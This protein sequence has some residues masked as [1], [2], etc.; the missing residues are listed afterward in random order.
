M[1]NEGVSAFQRVAC[2]RLAIHLKRAGYS[3]E[4]ALALLLPWAEKNRPMPGKQIICEKEIRQQVK[5]A[6]EKNYC[7]LGCHDPA[8][9]PYC[10]KKC[11]VFL[12]HRKQN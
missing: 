10:E 12:S 9:S 11:P 8:V 2:F 1:L 4:E 3:H 7:S 6:F 5:C